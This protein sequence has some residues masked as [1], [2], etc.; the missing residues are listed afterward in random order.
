[1]PYDIGLTDADAHLLFRRAAHATLAGLCA[2]L[3]AD[4]LDVALAPAG[5]DV[6]VH[7]LVVHDP[8]D[9]WAAALE[10]GNVALAVGLEPDGAV[11]AL[12]GVAGAPPAAFVVKPRGPMPRALLDAAQTAGVAVLVTDPEVAWGRLYTLLGTSMAAQD[13]RLP[14]IGGVALG[15]LFALADAT[16]AMANGPITIE[17][18]S[19]RVLAFSRD[20]QEVDAGRT[21]TILGRRVPE[22]WIARLEREGALERLRAGDDVV[23]VDLPGMRPRRA[24]AIRAGGTMLGS[25]WLAQGEDAGDQADVALREAARVAALHLLR[26]RVADD[27]ERRLRGG[28]L[29]ALLRGDGP[30]G[31][32]LERL[33][34]TTG[35][36]YVVIAI[37]PAH[38]DG[39][40]AALVRERLVDLV[41]MHL[42]AYRRDVAAAVLGDRVYVLVS[43]RGDG[44]RTDLRRLTG[45]CL[46]RAS[47]SLGVALRAGIGDHAA[48]VDGIAALRASAD[49]CLELGPAD[50]PVT[51]FE[52]VHGRA[53]V[54][55]VQRFLAE[56]P[57]AISRELR[58]LLEH[59]RAHAS[60]YT[61]TLRAFFDCLGDTGAAA[62]RLQVHPNTLR[63]RLRRIVEIT[64]ADFNDADA[65]FAL[66]LQLRTVAG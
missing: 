25:I 60:E 54:A 43:S 14:G 21:A 12:A 56:R 5:L 34:L 58:R 27:L 50:H 42:Q 30:A 41:V 65:R 46:Q 24:I 4:L 59:D 26:H 20:G 15:D 66:E 28:L 35:A 44:D 39:P 23:A 33:G 49:R 17:D 2:D 8:L 31:S 9:G 61:A 52:E 29:A 16:A 64:G 3:G 22:Q 51:M 57:T 55:D 38:A 10:P 48:T 19:N 32:G 45:D 13:V 40:E 11:A 53:L 18:A 36:G 1:V 62:A 7:D 37:E 63:Y 6:P 47:R